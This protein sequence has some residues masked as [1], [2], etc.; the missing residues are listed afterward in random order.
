[1]QS[2]AIGSG[3]RN[4][5]TIVNQT[6]GVAGGGG[7]AGVPQPRVLGSTIGENAY[8]IDGM[9]ATNPVMST[10][11]AVLNFDAI[12]EIQLQTGGFEAEYGRA[13]GGIINLIS[14]S[15]GNRFTGTF[16][17]R[18]RDDSF[19]ESG[20]HYDASELSSSYYV[21]GA[22]L[23]GPVVRDRAW[24]FASLGMVNDVFTPIGSPTTQEQQGQNLLGKI[25]WQ[26]GPNWR[27]AGKYTTDPTTWDNWNA[28]RTVMPE[29]TNHKKGTTAIA[30]AELNSV[31]S[32]SLVWNTTLGRYHYESN[33]LPQSGD[34]AAIGHYNFDTD[35][36]TVNYGNQQYWDTT[37][38][39]LTTD[40]T[41][42]VDG[43]AGSH[44]FKGGLEYSDLSF[45]NTNCTT[46]TP[47]G[48]QC[49]PNGVGFFFQDIDEGGALPFFMWEDHTSGPT[50]YAGAVSTAFVQDA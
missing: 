37:R 34:L 27:L 19:Q 32:D 16:D 25:T 40:F 24:F 5:T 33:V 18:Y 20:Q 42:F 36:N 31:L 12:G 2:S 1:M 30:S 21:L 26:I 39:D 15:G 48:E 22:T 35:L 44:E 17:A 3:N 4:Y 38:I 10:A 7:W 41:W 14:K 29:A 13:T 9:D 43:L 46:G 11:T 23:G 50:D 49:V 47:N 45:T 28:D 8:F 6:A